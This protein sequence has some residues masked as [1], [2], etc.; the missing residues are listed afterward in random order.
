MESSLIFFNPS[1]TTFGNHLKKVGSPDKP[2]KIRTGGVR[3]GS[4]Y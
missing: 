1:L 3:G 2:K 4:K